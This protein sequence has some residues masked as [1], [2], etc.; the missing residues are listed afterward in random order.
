MYQCSECDK[1]YDEE[2][3]AMFLD[4]HVTMWKRTMVFVCKNCMNKKR[5]EGFERM[6]REA[7]TRKNEKG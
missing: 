2:D 3:G 5:R 4:M 6:K 7:K 1:L